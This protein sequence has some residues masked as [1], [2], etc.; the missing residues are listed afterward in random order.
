[1]NRKIRM[2]QKMYGNETDFHLQNEGTI[3]LLAPLNSKAE[4]FIDKYIKEPNEEQGG[5]QEWAGQVVVEPR[6][7]GPLVDGI[8]SQGFT[9]AE[10]TNIIGVSAYPEQNRVAS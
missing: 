7:V 8:L 4:S 2:L 6:Y 9:I 5:V 3:M 1:M 10:G